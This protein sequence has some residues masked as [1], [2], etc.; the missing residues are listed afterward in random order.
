MCEELLLGY[1]TPGAIF[2]LAFS[3]YEDRHA[4]FLY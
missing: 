4:V 3:A 2:W 1:V